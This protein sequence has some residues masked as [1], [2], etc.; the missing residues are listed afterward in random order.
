METESTPDAISDTLPIVKVGETQPLQRRRRRK[1]LIELDEEVRPCG[2]TEHRLTV[3]VKIGDVPL[4][5]GPDALHATCLPFLG[6]DRPL[7]PALA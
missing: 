3:Q 5:G 1:L 4:S 6:A 7:R 2:L